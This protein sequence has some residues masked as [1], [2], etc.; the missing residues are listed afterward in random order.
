A[1]TKASADK[2]PE[3]EE[4]SQLLTNVLL[5]LNDGDLPRLVEL[6]EAHR[7]DYERAAEGL[8]EGDPLP[9]VHKK[10]DKKWHKELLGVLKQCTGAGLALFG[11]MI[12][13][14]PEGRIDGASQVAH[15]FTTH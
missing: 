6:A 15:A 9:T 2:S 7:R 8:S 10:K 14:L 3:E 5:Y 11:R 13:A 1:K 12:A 4:A